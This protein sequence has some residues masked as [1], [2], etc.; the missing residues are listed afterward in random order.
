MTGGWHIRRNV[1]PQTVE[2]VH[3]P[4][5]LFQRIFRILNKPLIF[6]YGVPLRRTRGRGGWMVTSRL[7][8]FQS[9]YND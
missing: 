1:K 9:L 2:I 8:E 7:S 5:P 4:F 3:S 6:P